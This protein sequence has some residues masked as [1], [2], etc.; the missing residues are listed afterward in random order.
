MEVVKKE[1]KTSTKKTTGATTKKEKPVKKES[2]TK[3][4]KEA[5]P[6]EEIK[7]DYIAPIIDTTNVETETII[8]K[9]D[10]NIE[11]HVE[12]KNEETNTTSIEDINSNDKVED[13]ETNIEK[14][15]DEIKQPKRNNSAFNHY[16][17]GQTSGW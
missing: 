15:E 16:W 17:N 10:D 7:K 3:G 13:T 6:T 14:K 4:K 2:T 1:E 9:T 11:E 12:E 5:I 8:T